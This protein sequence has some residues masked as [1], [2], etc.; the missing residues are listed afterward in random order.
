ML[1]K[2]NVIGLKKNINMAKKTVYVSFYDVDIPIFTKLYARNLISRIIYIKSTVFIPFYSTA[3][4]LI[5]HIQI[6]FFRDFLFEPFNSIDL[7]LY[8]HFV[9]VSL[10]E[11]LV[12]NDTF[13]WVKVFTDR[14]RQRTYQS[15]NEN[16]VTLLH[17][18]IREKDGLAYGFI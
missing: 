10:G 11:V 8:A 6:L 14:R 16:N 17:Y 13:K 9:D 5:Y 18:Y 4:L 15:N 3:A 7:N 1:I 2:I 12:R